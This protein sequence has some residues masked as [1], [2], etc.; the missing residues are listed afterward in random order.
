M[1]QKTSLK[2][3]VNPK[4][5]I[6]SKPTK[7]KQL[8]EA[9]PEFTLYFNKYGHYILLFT[10]TVLGFIVFRD[11]L[12]FNKLYLFKDIGSDSINANYPHGYQVAYYMKHTSLFP[13]WSFYQGMGQNIFPLS[14]PDPFYFLLML[15]GE[16]NLAYGIAIMEV[17]KVLCAGILFYLF[18]TKINLGPYAALVGSICYAFSSF[19]IL[20]GAW[21]IFSTEAVYFA[22][23]L[24]AFEKLFQENKMLLFPIAVCLICINQPFDLFPI[25]L[26]LIIY[27]LFRLYPTQPLLTK[28]TGIFLAKIAGLGILGILMS[29]FFLFADLL[30]MIESPRVGG[31]SSYFSKLLSAPIFGVEGS[32]HN[33]T[34]LLRFFSADMLG[35]GSSFN[36][37]YN[38][39]EAPLFYFGLINLLLFP[40]VFPFLDKKR[41]MVYS[42]FILLFILP[43]LFPFFRYAFWL[44]T[45]DYY[46]LYSLF[47]VVSLSICSLNALNFI[48]R[49]FKV[50][51]V[52]LAISLITLL[53]I[54]FYPYSREQEIADTSMQSA[55]C[56]FLIF[57]AVLIASMSS[58]RIGNVSKLLA[59]LLVC[60]ELIIFSNRTINSRPVITGAEFKSKT[61]YNDYTKDAVAYLKERDKGFY[62]IQKEY[63]SGTAMHG[64]M[65]DAQ[66]QN[67]YGTLSYNS[68]NQI[69]YIKFLDELHIIDGKNEIQTRWAAGFTNAPFLH[70]FGSIK[71][72]LTKEKNSR[73]LAVNYDSMAKVGDVIILKNKYSLPLGFSYNKYIPKSV[74]HKFSDH[75]KRATLFK[76]FV[77]DDSLIHEIKGM[78][79]FKE[80]D[81]TAIFQWTDYANDIAQLKKDTLAI[82][83]FNQNFIDGEVT[84]TEKKVL[85]FS[86]PFDPGWTVRV[87][88]KPAKLLLA[89]IGFSGVLLEPG[90]HQVELSFLPRFYKTGAIFSFIG[91]IMFLIIIRLIYFLDSRN[92]R[93]QQT[94]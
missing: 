40:Q 85:F 82:K 76:A 28:K 38:Y 11:F 8:K 19:I 55:A 52:V 64:S 63:A 43:I 59:L 81:T 4:K 67:F 75:Q 92:N 49:Q 70:P 46:R 1:K 57:Y 71:Y 66:V 88:G 9:F 31:E 83:T 42:L 32:M 45:G 65:N 74:F 94:N 93:S 13:K 39:L 7:R 16:N 23:L 53:I 50:N 91:I 78:P 51:Y 41:R 89:N 87:D 68:F 24:F 15:A 35:T 29:S 25:T 84:S 86:I 37:W 79:E 3:T 6:A 12:L 61:G 30:Q 69:N 90:K 58:R 27:I 14:I 22:L 54:L 48:D 56:L 72:A 21:N 17:I 36:G 5:G 34:A 18:L 20:G 60:T 33:A 10:L 47:V 73:L 26:F 62:R 77:L 80:S 2:K 44:F